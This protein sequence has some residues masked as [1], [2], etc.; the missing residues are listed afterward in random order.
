MLS[1]FELVNMTNAM[2]VLQ[3]PEILRKRPRRR[4]VI[5]LAIKPKYAKAIYEG[6]KNWE[7]RKAPPPIFRE[8]YVYESAPVSAIT[9]TVTFSDSITGIPLSVWDIVK[10]NKCYTQNNPGVSFAEL[11]AYT[12]KNTL[13]ALRVFDFKRFDSPYPLPS[14]AR[15][16]QNWGRYYLKPESE[17]E[18]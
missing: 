6:R 11:E 2:Y 3:H 4:S 8:M 12:G 14:G 13:T 15:P 7:F 10:T 17:V 5:V 16:P 1:G 9:G 18:K